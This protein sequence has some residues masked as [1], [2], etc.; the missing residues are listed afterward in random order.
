MECSRFFQLLKIKI[1][2]K[3]IKTNV[4][5]L[6]PVQ[7][8]PPQVCG[9]ARVRRFRQPRA[10]KGDR[11]EGQLAGGHLG[12]CYHMFLNKRYD[13]CVF[14]AAMRRSQSTGDIDGRGSDDGAA[15]YI[16]YIDEGFFV[17]FIVIMTIMIIV[18]LFIK[19]TTIKMTIIRR[20]Q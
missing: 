20:A 16:Q 9:V 15:E 1:A 19:I 12:R 6:F 7:I 5:L 13:K 17:T 18:F 8:I 2:F 3:I 11:G 4:G 10:G 14:Q